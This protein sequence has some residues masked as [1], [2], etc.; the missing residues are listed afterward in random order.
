MC[1][2]AMENSELRW[3]SRHGDSEEVRLAAFNE[4]LRRQS[5]PNDTKITLRFSKALE[6]FFLRST[7]PVYAETA[8]LVER[9]RE[10]RRSELESGLFRQRTRLVKAERSLKSKPTAKA[11]EEQRIASDKVEWHR[12][13]LEN[14]ERQEVRDADRRIYPMWYTMVLANVDRKRVLMPM[15]YH[16]RQGGKSAS[17]DKQFGGLYNARRDSLNGYWRR[18]WRSQHAIMPAQAFYENVALEV[19]ER[20]ELQPGE[21]SRN[22]V[23]EFKPDSREPMLFACLWDKW[24]KAGEPDL[25]SFAVITDDPPAEVAATGHDRCPILLKPQNVAAWLSPE[26]RDEAELQALLDDRPRPYFNHLRLAA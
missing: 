21:K 1:Y 26:G 13:Q 5:F 4:L 16:C 12:L 24:E 23:L 8:G 3:L 7:D 19:F 20:R 9:R 18:I 15:R 25:Y 2:S 11:L 17:I 14:L 6:S 10:M 22:V